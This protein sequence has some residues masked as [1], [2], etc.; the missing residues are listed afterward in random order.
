MDTDYR[1]KRETFFQALSY[2]TENA[3]KLQLQNCYIEDSDTDLCQNGECLPFEDGFHL[4]KCYKGFTGTFCN[5]DD[6]GQI[7]TSPFGKFFIIPMLGTIVI[8][9]IIYSY[10]IIRYFVIAKPC[11]RE[12]RRYKKLR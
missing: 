10:H 11:K 7:L 2:R 4:C 8:A 6:L 12:N 5:H 9:L 1:I 3:R